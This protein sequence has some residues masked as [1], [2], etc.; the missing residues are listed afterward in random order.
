MKLLFSTSAILLAFTAFALAQTTTGTAVGT[1]GATATTGAAAKPKLLAQTDKTFI[2]NTAESMYFLTTIAEKTK[3]NAGS[4]TVKMLGKK[5]L[6]DLNKIW[7][8]V[9][10]VASANGE[11]MPSELKGADKNHAKKLDKPERFDKEFLDLAGKESKKL[12]RYMESGAKMAQN[13][14][15]KAIAER[16]IP[17]VKSHEDEIEKA[18]KEIKK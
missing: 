14:E 10:G 6:N 4:E 16:W 2:K 15:L 12:S 17:T 7:G 8:E 18:E 9:G 13:A 5:M 11:M 3:R 1:T